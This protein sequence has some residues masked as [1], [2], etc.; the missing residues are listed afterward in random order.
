MRRAPSLVVAA[1]IAVSPILLSAPASAQGAWNKSPFTFS[2]FSAPAPRSRIRVVQPRRERAVPTVKAASAALP[3]ASASVIAA[4]SIGRTQPSASQAAPASAL[5]A[6]VAL[7]SQTITVWDVD[8][9]M[10][11]SRVS[12]GTVGHATPTGIYSVIQRNRYHES[13]IYSGAP[14]PFMQRI[15]WSGIALHGGVVPNY[16]ASHGCIRLPHDFAPKLWAAGRIGMRVLVAP[17]E[18][19]AQPISHPALPQP[20]LISPEE[21]DAMIA[22]LGGTA[23]ALS[24]LEAAAASQRSLTPFEVATR[25]KRAAASLVEV[26]R[27]AARD[28]LS[29]AALASAE[30]NAAIATVREAR[31]DVADALAEANAQARIADAS[32][33]TSVAV[34]R[35]AAK[36]AAD[37]RLA[38]TQSRL[39]SALA[40]EARKDPLAFAAA[41]AA[42]EAEDAA[43]EAPDLARAV[44]RR[45][46]PVSVYINTTEGQIYVRQGFEQ[47]LDAS[48]EIDDPLTPLGTHV[49]TAMAPTGSGNR[50]SWMAVTM[51]T[52]QRGGTAQQVLDRIKIPDKVRDEIAR[53]LWTGGSL[54]ISEHGISTETGKGTDFVILTK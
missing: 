41:R 4:T 19:R 34:D 16:P 24:S 33:V 35:I 22:P 39:E 27:T 5:V 50:M 30:A 11:H 10:L 13:N 47:V 12:T 9:P 43:E 7:D 20:L 45:A 52:S 32:A 51:P 21:L 15:T 14:M 48:I 25:L 42:R 37:A 17:T 28:A 31:Q 6:V 53:R 44:A 8:G 3:V 38:A 2:W 1:A 18:A 40:E 23:G 46:D 49:F 36:I 54:I 26:R 29:Q